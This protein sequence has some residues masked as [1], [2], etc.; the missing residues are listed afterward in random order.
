MRHSNLI[1][2]ISIHLGLQ[3]NSHVGT[4]TS[5][6]SRTKYG[7]YRSRSIYDRDVALINVCGMSATLKVSQCTLAV[8]TGL[9]SPYCLGDVESS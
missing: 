8:P 6:E 9:T 7:A 3:H 2:I 5:E 4:E 1:I